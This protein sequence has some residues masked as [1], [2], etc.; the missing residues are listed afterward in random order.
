MSFQF[1][2]DNAENISVNRKK[3]VGISQARDGTVRTTSFGGQVWSFTVTLPNGPK[4]T[5]VRQDISKIEALDRV[6]TGNIQFNKSGQEWIMQYQGN[7]SNVSAITATVP[8]SGNT[9][10]LTGGQAA[11]GY[12]FRAGDIVQLGSSGKVY[13][14]TA[15]V[16]Y[17]SNT[18]T[19]HRP[20]ID[21]AGTV[22]LRV[23]TNCV[24]NVI[25]SEFPDW[26]LVARDQIAWSGPFVFYEN[27]V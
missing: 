2:I 17:N 25:C 5:N 12:N 14:V 13:T 11:S 27:L 18:V 9:I 10:T 7:C 3:K 16:V 22:T 6:T 24:F 4:W 23:G 20:I 1:V 26:S 21:P 15:D 19:L 8:S